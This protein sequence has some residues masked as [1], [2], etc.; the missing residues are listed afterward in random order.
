[1]LRGA[2]GSETGQMQRLRKQA[3]E[4]GER[5]KQTNPKEKKRGTTKAKGRVEQTMEIKGVQSNRGSPQ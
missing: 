3:S 2:E 5:K 1:M 4:I